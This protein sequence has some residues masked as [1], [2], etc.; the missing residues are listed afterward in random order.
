MDPYFKAWQIDSQGR[1]SEVPFP[2]DEP[3]KDWNRDN[4]YAITPY[5]EGMF[6]KRIKHFE[7]MIFNWKPRN[8]NAEKGLASHIRSAIQLDFD[9][10]LIARSG[11]IDRLMAGLDW[12]EWW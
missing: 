8:P 5:Y 12:A 2:E 1:I 10:T 4:I 9:G 7:V 6:T 3:R 11:G